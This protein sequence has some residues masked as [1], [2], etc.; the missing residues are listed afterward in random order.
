M[1]RKYELTCVFDPQAGDSG[2]EA[3]VKKYEGLL[4][5]GGAV[6]AAVDRWG[7]RK[8]AYSSVGFKR[9]QQGYFALFQFTAEAGLVDQIQQ[10]LKLDDSVLRHLVVA[11]TGE[12]LRVPQ[13]APENVYIY[14][15]EDRG[16]P[17]FGRGRRDRDGSE[18][19]GPAPATSREEGEVQTRD[20]P[21]E[22]EKGVAGPEPAVET[23]AEVDA[24]DGQPAESG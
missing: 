12:F 11:V 3:L 4:K 18:R 22:E 21:A 9:R 14:T 2:F 17:R 6:V 7:L 13:L 19:R 20:K 10:G 5:S 15:R 1:T 16:G 8:L 24:A 23:V